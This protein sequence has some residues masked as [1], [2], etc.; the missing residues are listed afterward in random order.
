VASALYA[1]NARSLGQLTVF[2]GS[3]A[4]EGQGIYY[5]TEKVILRRFGVALKEVFVH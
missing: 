1:L 3:A 4:N 5:T 2:I